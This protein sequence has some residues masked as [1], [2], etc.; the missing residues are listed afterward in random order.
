MVVRCD[1]EFLR[2]LRLLAVV[3]ACALAPVASA[4]AAS[5]SG[6]I[7]TL[8]IAAEEVAWNYAPEGNVLAD[9]QC[10]ADAATWLSRGPRELPPVF[11]KAV[12]REYTDASFTQLKPRPPEWVHLGILGPLIRAEV[13][14][15]LVITLKNKLDFSVS[16]HAH[17]AL[18]DKASEGAGYPDGTIGAYKSDDYV[19]P[20]SSWTY[21]WDVPERAGPGPG[22]PSSIAWL[23]HSHV[24]APRDTNSGLVGVMLVTRRGEAR[25]DGSPKDADREFITLYEIF[26]EAQSR[27]A[28]RNTAVLVS[29]GTLDAEGE[30]DEAEE[31]GE[32]NLFHAI[33]GYIYGNLPMMHMKVGEHV[34]WYLVSLGGETDLH[35]PHWHGNTVLQ[36][37]HRTDVIELLPASMK[38]ADMRPDNPGVWMYHCHVNDHIRA[39]MAAR[40]EVVKP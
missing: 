38:V 22:D 39:G 1:F 24:D 27:L 25:L 11:R 21:H 8:F 31:S 34:R 40:Y 20:R 7:R 29:P 13:G 4:Q 32:A 33:N 5:D 36:E 9:M 2:G 35:T 37:G 26:D 30:S 14:D 17:G 10:C 18:Y 12:F 15:H 6:R 16:L 19:A 28:G 3:V 23:Y